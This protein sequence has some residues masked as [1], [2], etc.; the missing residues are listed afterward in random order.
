V[1]VPRI[2]LATCVLCEGGRG[3]EQDKLRLSASEA[4]YVAMPDVN[5]APRQNGRPVAVYSNRV[6]GIIC[7][8]EWYLI[9]RLFWFLPIT[10]LFFVFPG[11]IEV[12][13]A[14]IFTK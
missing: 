1:F 14:Q 11:R 13:V 12:I 6:D 2:N 5:T 4:I 3:E 9:S 8:D 10:K 7:F